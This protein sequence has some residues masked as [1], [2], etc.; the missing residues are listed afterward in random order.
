MLL[1][2][3][4]PCL[5]VL[6]LVDSNKAVMDKVLYYTRMTKISIIKASSGIA[7]KELF[8]VSSS[9]S[10]NVCIS[11]DSD[12]ENSGNNDT[13]NSD[14]IDSD[15]LEILSSSV[16]KLLQKREI[17]I[18]ANFAVTGWMICVITHICKDTKYNF[19]GDHKKQVNN[20]I[21]TLF[22]GSYEDKMAV[23]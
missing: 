9:S 7:N 3:F 2:I 15:M 1:K 4:F 12:T 14:S 22:H 18:N 10:F 11:S 16:C 17:H 21:K 5:C 8:P 19:D 13:D 20:A 23:T 6:C